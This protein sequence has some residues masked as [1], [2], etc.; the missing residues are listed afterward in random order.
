MSQILAIAGL[1]LKLL[2]HKRF[3]LALVAVWIVRLVLVV[4]LGRSNVSLPLLLPSLYITD[5]L[6]IVMACG[7]I[8]DDAERGTFAFV[9]SHGIDRRMYL[10]GKLL[11]VI[12]LATAFAVLAHVATVLMTPSAAG[13]PASPAAV[14]GRLIIGSAMSLARILVV[15]AVT[16][17]MAVALTNRYLASMGALLYVYG[18]AYL[19]QS[20]LSPQSA[21]A[22]LAESLLPWRDNFDRLAAMLFSGRLEAAPLATAIVQ[23][24]VYATLF[25]VLAVR[26]LGR[27]DL[28]YADAG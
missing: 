26:T 2:S 25:G 11:P 22:W 9:L 18:L 3:I 19:V 14:A 10:A 27:R 16:A 6:V 15:T 12:G 7:L 23:P 24:L 28:A 17:W 13:G 1:Q 4:E 8:A 21:G 5:L 20:V